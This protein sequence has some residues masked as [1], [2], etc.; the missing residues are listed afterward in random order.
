EVGV[1]DRRRRVVPVENRR[2]LAPELL[3]LL[4][5]AAVHLPV[6]LHALDMRIGGDV[7]LDWDHGCRAS[8]LCFSVLLFLCSIFPHS[9]TSEPSVPG[10]PLPLRARRGTRP[11]LVWARGPSQRA[12]AED[13]D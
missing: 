12:A 6:L 13:Y 3:R 5:R 9:D 1:Q 4:D 7:G 11:G 8:I 2:L 10:M